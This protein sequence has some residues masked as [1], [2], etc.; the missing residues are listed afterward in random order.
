MEPIE[1]AFTV[2][3]APTEA[4]GL[5]T[6]RTS[7]WWPK[8]HSVSGDPALQVVFE[9][10]VGG[11]VLERTPAGEEHA[12]GTITAWE[13]PG[14]LAYRWHLRQDPSDATDVE[15]TFA[16][17]A[18]GGTLVRIVHGGWER[19]GERGPSLR[20]RNRAGW[21]GVLPRYTAACGREGD[22]IRVHG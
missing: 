11:Q 12:W 2:A 17:A 15:I 22:V 10:R 16:E 6:Q 1:L 8:T 13:P 5:W 7:L 18:G 4:F 20:D 3:C 14:R 9:P 21:S 19:L